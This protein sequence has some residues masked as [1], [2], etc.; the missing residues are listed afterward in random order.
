MQREVREGFADHV[1][2]VSVIIP[3]Y[4]RADLVGQTIENMLRQTLPPHEVIVVDDGSTDAS[5]EVIRAFGGRVTLIEQANGGPGS[6]RNT[7]LAVATGDFIQFM[8]S[9]D[10]ASL[11]KLAVQAR[12]LAATGADMAYGPWIQMRMAG[13]EVRWMDYVLQPEPAPSNRPLYETHLR[14][15]ALV[16]QNCLF[17]RAFLQARGALKTDL[18]GTEDFEYLT[19]IFLA[20]P[21]VIFTPECMVY[22]RLHDSGKLSGSGTTATRKAGELGRAFAYVAADLQ[23]APRPLSPST[24]FVFSFT[25]W[26]I[27]RQMTAA[28]SFPPAE[29]ERVRAI[30]APFP[31]WAYRAFALWDRLH[32]ALRVRLTGIP[33]VHAY[34]ARRPNG[35]E[36]AR[37]REAGLTLDVATVSPEATV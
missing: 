24:R 17:T 6:A 23:R 1:G 5:V 9:D 14:R 20:E 11:N 18:L 15:W 37:M 7:G 10:L 27:W 3:S 33:W 21:R 8:D 32:A 29:V 12:A 19:R 35:D 13:R 16:L 28:R 30:A 4:N 2:K 34:R 26:R 25:A 36:L 22:Y 31:A